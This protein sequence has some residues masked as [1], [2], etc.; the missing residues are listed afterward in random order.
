MQVLA[1]EAASA[2][3]DA[4]TAAAATATAARPAGSAAAAATTSAASATAAAAGVLH[5]RLV[6]FLVEDKESPQ[7]D[8]R[9]LLFT[10]DD[11]LTR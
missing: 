9:D 4:A 5:A 6:D 3:G 7:A 2:P 11:F 1:K 10:E 8:V